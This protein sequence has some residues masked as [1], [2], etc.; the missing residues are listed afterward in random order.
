MFLNDGVRSG[1][2]VTAVHG[3]LRHHRPGSWLRS[4]EDRSEGPQSL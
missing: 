1:K 4:M 3:I 2:L